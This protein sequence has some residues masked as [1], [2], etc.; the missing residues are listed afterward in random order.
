MSCY[1]NILTLPFGLVSAF[2]LLWQFLNPA[3]L[4]IGL[5]RLIN[6]DLT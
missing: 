1:D 2:L 6:V 4:A 3:V 5:F